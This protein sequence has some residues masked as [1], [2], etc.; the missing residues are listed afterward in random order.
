MVDD[1]RNALQEFIRRFGLLSGDQTPCGKPLPPSDAHALMLLLAAA[2]QGIAQSVLAARLGFDKSTA[3]RLVARL[4]ERGQVAPAP[5]SGD[6]RT[7]PVKLTS[8]GLRLAQEIDRASRARFARLLEG[9][10]ERRRESVLRALRD[11]VS[12]LDGLK[13]AEQGEDDR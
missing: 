10:P 13:T 5:A 11:I 7:K 6:A 2:E 4:T 8:K 9:V 12:A 1:F 3:S